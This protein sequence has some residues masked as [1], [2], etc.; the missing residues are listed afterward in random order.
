ALGLA[1]A[2][3]ATTALLGAIAPFVPR[4][5]EI[6]ID[7]RVF[8]FL[9]ALCSGVAVAVGLVPALLATRT[10][11]RT[12]LDQARGR[13]TFGRSQRWLRAGLVVAEVAIALT[14]AIGSG[15]LVRELI[16][17]RATESG[18][19]TRD[20]LTAHVGHRMT[21]R[22]GRPLDEDIRPFSD[23]EARAAQL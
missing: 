19:D 1:L 2:W 8:L 10:G 12:A 22:Q 18:M 4:A 23:I 9:F 17:L 14:L 21:P 7:W 3:I 15:L 13:S 11:P 16:R 20:V 6:G 5:H